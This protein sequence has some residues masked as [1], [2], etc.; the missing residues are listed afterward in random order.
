MA[1]RTD[2]AIQ[3][4][5]HQ[6][7]RVMEERRRR[8]TL[9]KQAIERG[10]A[11]GRL[12]ARPE[13]RA[14][15]AALAALRAE[16]GPPSDRVLIAEGD[17]WFDFPFTDVLKE[18]EDHHGY[19]IESVSHKGDT[20]EEMAYSGGQLDDLTR[21]IE[22]VVQNGKTL[23]AILLSGGGNDVA[24]DEFGFLLNHASSPNPGLNDQ[25]VAGLVDDR[26][27]HAYVTVLSAVTQVCQDNLGA[28]LPILVHGYDYAVP[29]GRGFWSGWWLLPGPWLEPGFREKGYADL[30]QNKQIVQDLIDRF[31]GMLQGLPALPGLGHVHHVDLR[32]TLP[33]DEASYQ[34]W[35]SDELHPTEDGFEAVAD[36]FVAV[37][38]P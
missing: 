25:V 21:A 10:A 18:L 1:T 35:W 20:V 34:D 31:N 22:K 14:E 5:R 36:R 30:D 3:A 37:L 7:Q 13:E 17:S 27:L 23:E 9:R 32:G 28:P 15:P 26:I 24:G 29:D 8:R 16:L 4:G 33:R 12:A 2:E 19:E 38:P 11:P 6:A